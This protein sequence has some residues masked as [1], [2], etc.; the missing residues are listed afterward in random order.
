[1]VHDV[2]CAE[3]FSRDTYT[4]DFEST[5]PPHLTPQDLSFPDVLTS[6]LASNSTSNLLFRA[7]TLTLLNRYPRI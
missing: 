1:M 6:N 7:L 3:A 4:R 5:G 2:C